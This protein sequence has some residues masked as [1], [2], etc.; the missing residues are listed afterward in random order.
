MFV[1]QVVTLRAHHVRRSLTKGP[2]EENGVLPPTLMILE[3]IYHN[4]KESS[5][6]MSFWNG[7]I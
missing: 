1:N 5:I 6:Q 3:L 7:Y 4:S 2:Q